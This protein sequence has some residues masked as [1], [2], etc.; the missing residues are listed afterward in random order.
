M[1]KVEKMLN[2]AIQW[3]LKEDRGL[4][5][6]YDAII[7][8][9]EALFILF[10]IPLHK[11]IIVTIATYILVRMLVYTKEKVLFR[12][13]NNSLMEIEICTRII[14]FILAIATFV[15][16]SYSF[17]AVILIAIQAIIY[18]NLKN[19]IN[20]KLQESEKLVDENLNKNFYKKVYAKYLPW[21]TEEIAKYKIETLNFYAIKE[22]SDVIVRYPTKLY[23]IEKNNTVPEKY[24]TEKNSCIEKIVHKKKFTKYFS[25][26]KE[27]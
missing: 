16:A 5:I 27:E 13:L 9:C 18:Q 11:Y 12:K 22:G 21:N 23:L 1:K 10:G 15:I 26:E 4:R 20:I 14:F 24:L 17:I 6:I 7:I 2:T 3:L 8:I 19:D 25:L